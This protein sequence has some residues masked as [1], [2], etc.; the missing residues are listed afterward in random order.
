MNEITVKF[1]GFNLDDSNYSVGKVDFSGKDTIS[2]HAIPKSNET[3]LEDVRRGALTISVEGM[4]IGSGYDDLRTNLDSLKAAL[5]TNEQQFII[6][7]DRYVMAK[8]RDFDYSYTV[9]GGVAK[10][11][12]LFMIGFPYWRKNNATTDSRTP[13]SGVD[14]TITNNGNAPARARVVI[15]AAGGV[16]ADDCAFD[17]TT[18]G[19]SFRYR[20]TIAASGVFVSDNRYTSDSFL[21]TNAGTDDHENYEGD[22]I[23]I[24][25]GAN[26]VRFTGV[27]GTTVSI[28]FKDT[29]EA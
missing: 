11:K 24:Y 15:T 20:G 26:L 2:A 5:R 18:S 22:F 27:A 12:A 10:Y 1:N 19:T 3:I 28:T 13:T 29:W 9:M 8:M 7:D 4:V 6:D 23:T 21:A 16:I 17:N 25:P 14:Y